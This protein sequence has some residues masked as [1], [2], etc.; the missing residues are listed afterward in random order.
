MTPFFGC[1][2]ARASSKNIA[3]IRSGM[4]SR[5]GLSTTPVSGSLLRRWDA[6]LNMI[7]SLRQELLS[8]LEMARAAFRSH[9]GVRK[10][11]P[12]P[13]AKATTDPGSPMSTRFRPRRSLLLTAIAVSP[14][15]CTH[16]AAPCCVPSVLRSGRLGWRVAEVRR[17]DAVVAAALAVCSREI[18]PGA[19]GLRTWASP[20][21]RS[22]TTSRVKRLRRAFERVEARCDEI[23]GLE[24]IDRHV[25]GCRTGRCT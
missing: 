20:R 4:G 3:A 16:A 15:F 2:R 13:L 9:S 18:G 23:F 7:G 8:S 6:C 5:G 22:R 19:C 14:P 10:T 1:P 24:A 25:V 12:L 17:W 21:T 11:H